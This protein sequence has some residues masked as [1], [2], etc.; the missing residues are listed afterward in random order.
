MFGAPGSERQN[1]AQLTVNE[2]DRSCVDVRAALAW[3]KAVAKT[4]IVR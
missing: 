1:I 3:G 2:I 4:N